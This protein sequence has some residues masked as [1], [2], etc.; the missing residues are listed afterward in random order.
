[1]ESTEPELQ[2]VDLVFPSKFY[3][4]RSC[5]GRERTGR[6]ARRRKRF[7]LQCIPLCRY[8]MDV[9]PIQNKDVLGGSMMG[10]LRHVLL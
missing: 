7:P 5:N 9:V 2:N 6:Q 1:M 3:L 10:T 8:N 4:N